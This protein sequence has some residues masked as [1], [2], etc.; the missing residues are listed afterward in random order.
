MEKC[1]AAG[2]ND[3]VSKPIRPADLLKTI[4][5]Y[6]FVNTPKLL[7]I[8]RSERIADNLEKIT[9][10]L[11]KI[12]GSPERITDNLEKIAD[13]DKLSLPDAGHPTFDIS[14]AIERLG[15]S[16]G[17]YIKILKEFAEELGLKSIG[18][19]QAFDGG[20]LDELQ[21]LVHSLKGSSGSICADSL[22][23]TCEELDHSCRKL[24][25]SVSSESRALPVRSLFKEAMSSIEPLV[26]E[27]DN[28]IRELVESVET[29]ELLPTGSYDLDIESV[30]DMDAIKSLLANLAKELDSFNPLKS[31]EILDVLSESLNDPT[32]HEMIVLVGNYDFDEARTLLNDLADKVGLTL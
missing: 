27:L 7:N 26:M 9:D 31:R 18:V 16:R 10:N 32:V 22:F 12:T 28:K 17:I 19:K 2:M 3:Y 29:I 6:L 8:I 13:N 25:D 23:Q 14:S 11:N 24:M 15:I 30:E 1:L 5:K 21:R 4:S 20:N